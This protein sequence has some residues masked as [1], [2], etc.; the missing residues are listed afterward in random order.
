[1]PNADDIASFPGRYSRTFF[2]LAAPFQRMQVL[3]DPE[4][5]TATGALSFLLVNSLLFSLVL[6]TSD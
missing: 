6:S 5:L 4:D 3:L 1:M 2:S